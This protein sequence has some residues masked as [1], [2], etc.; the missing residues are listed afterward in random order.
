MRLGEEI[1][2]ASFLRFDTTFADGQSAN[3]KFDA[4]AIRN[5]SGLR[6]RVADAV[7]Y[8]V[9][10]YMPDMIVA[11]PNGANWLGIDIAWRLG[12]ANLLLK[13]DENNGRIDY[14]PDGQ[15]ALES[16]R[17]VVI[18]EDVINRRSTTSKVLAL[19]G[20]RDRAVAVC[21]IFDRGVEG[22]IQNISVPVNAVY[23]LAIPGMLESNSLLWDFAREPI[24]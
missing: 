21:A 7:A 2:R 19:S 10:E 1:L 14:L 22:E 6:T 8:L 13:K 12:T 24:N 4:D 17:K 15:E 5:S 3:N 23:A 9:L 16:A 18:I 11:V 20:M